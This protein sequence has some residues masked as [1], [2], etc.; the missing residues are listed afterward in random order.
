MK[1]QAQKKN[2][3][4][5]KNSFSVLNWLRNAINDLAVTGYSELVLYTF[6]ACLYTVMLI[7]LGLSQ[8]KSSNIILFIHSHVDASGAVSG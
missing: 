7:P 6:S 8:G 5:D 1:H 4:E 3:V 2:N